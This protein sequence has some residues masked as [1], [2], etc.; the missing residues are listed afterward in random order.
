MCIRDSLVALCTWNNRKS[1]RGSCTIDLVTCGTVCVRPPSIRDGGH[2]LPDSRDSREP[3]ER[4][5][6]GLK[7]LSVRYSS[8][9][10]TQLLGYSPS[11]PCYGS[12]DSL[13]CIP[14]AGIHCVPEKA[15]GFFYLEPGDN[16]IIGVLIAVISHNGKEKT[17][18]AGRNSSFPQYCREVASRLARRPSQYQFRKVWG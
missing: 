6:D 11:Q 7:K 16:Q 12:A 3:V 13:P 18:A 17:T 9:G 10:N 5:G 15:N 14:L 1:M 2:C 8:L 4:L